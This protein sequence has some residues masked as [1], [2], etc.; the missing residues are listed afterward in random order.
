MSQNQRESVL[1]T[2][3]A[4]PT[5]MSGKMALATFAMVRKPGPFV[6]LTGDTGS[7]PTNFMLM[8]LSLIT[9]ASYSN[10]ERM[11]SRG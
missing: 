6:S 3:S 10:T 8:R 4:G 1:P 7:W 9:L 5:E 2:M 11:E